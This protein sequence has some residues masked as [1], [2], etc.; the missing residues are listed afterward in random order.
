MRLRR[1]VPRPRSA[2]VPALAGSL[3]VHWLCDLCNGAVGGGGVDADEDS[4]AGDQNG[5]GEE[6][7][8]ESLTD[9]KS[10]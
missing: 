3:V 5:L 8:K 10:G 1:A 2:L 4:G 9:L 7:G 6:N